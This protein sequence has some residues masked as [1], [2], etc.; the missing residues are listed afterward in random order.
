MQ[1]APAIGRRSFR[2]NR[3]MLALG[4]NSGNL[5]VDDSC[6]PTAATTQE[7]GI[8]LRG[9]PADNRPVADFLLGNKSGWQHRVD[10]QDVQP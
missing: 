10:H 4:Q 3:D 2:K 6:M 1:Q 7:N 8:V 9:Q 5:G